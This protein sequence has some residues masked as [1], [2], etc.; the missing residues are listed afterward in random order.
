MKN[1]ENKGQT[2]TSALKNAVAGK[3]AM[4]EV[5]RRVITGR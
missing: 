5:R 4:S 3:A 2:V 1:I